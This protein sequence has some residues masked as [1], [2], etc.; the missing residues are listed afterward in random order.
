MISFVRARIVGCWFDLM[1]RVPRSQQAKAMEILVRPQQLR[2]LQR[3]HAAPPRISRRQKRILAVLTTK[4]RDVT[5]G[6]RAR[7]DD[8]MLLFTPATVLKWQ[9]AL[10]RRTWTFTRVRPAGR[11]TIA[12]AGEALML[13]LAS[14]H[15]RWGSSKRQGEVLK[16]GYT[17]GRSAVRD[18]LKRRHVPLAPPRGRH[19][20]T[21]STFLH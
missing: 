13:R 21:W 3:K 19:G 6:V 10:V 1:M 14:E 15:A 20:S 9:R 17:V 18:V 16:L 8:G 12:P 2:I 4:W 11:T 5:G 7:L